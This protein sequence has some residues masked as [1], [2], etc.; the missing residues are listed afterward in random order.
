[1][2]RLAGYSITFQVYVLWL[3]EYW[4]MF[5]GVSATHVCHAGFIHTQELHVHA[6][7]G[8]LLVSI[9]MKSMNWFKYH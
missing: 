7:S 2:K 3:R 5:N 8:M 1:M 9:F 6:S 4:N